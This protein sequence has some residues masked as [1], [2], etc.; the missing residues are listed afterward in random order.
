MTSRPDLRPRTIGENLDA[1]FKL[2]TSN[3]RVLVIVAAMVL[4]PVAI[5]NGVI[6]ASLGSSNLLDLLT[7]TEDGALDFTGA[8]SYLAVTG[9]TALIGAI[10]SL[11]V[12][13]AVVRVIGD[14]YQGRSTGWREAIS[15]GFRRAF[16]V[17][18]TGLLIVIGAI[19][20]LVAVGIVVAIVGT[21]SDV[22][23]LTTAIFFFV[24]TV[25]AV[26]TLAYV[27][28]PALIVEHLGPIGAIRRSIGL[29]RARFWPTFWTAILAYVI[30]MVISLIIGGIVQAAVVIPA[31]LDSA[32]SGELSGGLITGVSSVS[33]A[34]V[35]IFTTPFTAAVGIAV[36]FDLRVRFEGFDLELLARDMD[37]IDPAPPIPRSDDDPFGLDTPPEQ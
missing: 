24:G 15:L 8:G 21:F 13:A 26:F 14:A 31:A 20:L 23:A 18:L 1:G 7:Q 3:F 4:I 16:P 35:S 11:I 34:V 9:L 17:F 32:G 5:L 2:F 28:V 37:R 19:G 6:S 36:Y 27:A 25:V 33:S 29:V 10:G 22:L 12:Q 30:V